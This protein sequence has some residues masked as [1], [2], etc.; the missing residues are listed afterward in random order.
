MTCHLPAWCLQGLT[1]REKAT[2]VNT[3]ARN[4]KYSSNE[5]LVG[6]C[7]S[8]PVLFSRLSPLP[9]IYTKIKPMLQSFAVLFF[10]SFYLFTYLSFSFPIFLEG[11]V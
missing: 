10:Y 11:G 2:T 7:T 8:Y 1:D 6:W 4:R 9:M 5:H 3:R